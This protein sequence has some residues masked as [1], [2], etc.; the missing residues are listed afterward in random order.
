[1]SRPNLS[2]LKNLILAVV[3]LP[4]GVIT[5]VT[6]LSCAPALQPALRWLIGIQGSSLNGVILVMVSFVSWTGLLSFSQSGDIQ[7]ANG[8]CITI[9]T[10]GG[11]VLVGKLIQ[12][13]P[14]YFVRARAA[15]SFIP[16][17]CALLMISVSTGHIARDIPAEPLLPTTGRLLPLLW[18]LAIGVGVG[19]IG[20]AGELG[21]ILVNPALYF[22][23]GRSILQSEGTALYILVLASLP[24]A[25]VHAIRR[26]LNTDAAFALSI[27]GVFGSLFGAHLAVK[28]LPDSTTTFVCG[29]TLALFSLISLFQR[30]EVSQ[31][32]NN[33][34]V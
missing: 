20:Y 16:L 14:I 27:G 19:F 29:G 30:P 8:F 24:A 32:R 1:M 12:R 17:A 2:Y 28:E 31:D 21:S 7:W 4:C 18:S 6:G 5:G 34:A 3:G 15:W 23:L 13:S 26:T 9:G 33:E 11:T 10:F 25:L 22:L